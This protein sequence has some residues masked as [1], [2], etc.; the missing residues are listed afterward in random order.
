M[1]VLTPSNTALTDQQKRDYVPIFLPGEANGRRT[2]TEHE[3]TEVAMQLPSGSSM[4]EIK[5]FLYAE[6]TRS[7]HHRT[8][9]RIHFMNSSWTVGAQK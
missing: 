1:Q 8:M 3:L 2:R 5:T 9:A 4:Q 7:R 6:H